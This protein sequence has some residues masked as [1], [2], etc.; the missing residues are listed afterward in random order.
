MKKLVIVE[1][2][3]KAKTIGKIIG[4][5]YVVKA[6]VGHVRDLPD[7]SLGIKISENDARF[8]PVYVITDN[9][10]GVVSDLK[11]TA[12]GCDEILLA[13]DPDREGEAI[14]WHGF[15]PTT[16]SKFVIKLTIRCIHSVVATT[17]HKVQ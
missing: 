8:D 11:K 10:K 14:A 12:R 7:R 1:S 2:P 17:R 5:D 6:S 9:K 3:A 13:S 16:N 4:N 15:F